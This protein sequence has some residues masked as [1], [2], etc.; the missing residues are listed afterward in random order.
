MKIDAQTQR[1]NRLAAAA[2]STD[3]YLAGR[4]SQQ[5][6]VGALREIARTGDSILRCEVRKCN[7]GAG[8]RVEIDGKDVR[9]CEGHLPPGL[10]H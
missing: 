1:A 5:A 4:I 6:L 2:I 9:V 3:A 7:A 8:F 10:P